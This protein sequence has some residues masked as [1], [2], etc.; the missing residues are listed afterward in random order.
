MQKITLTIFIA[1]SSFGFAQTKI[2]VERQVD[3]DKMTTVVT[4][5]GYYYGKTTCL[6]V[7]TAKKLKISNNPDNFQI[8]HFDTNF[9]EKGKVSSYTNIG[10]SLNNEALKKLDGYYTSNTKQ[11][12]RLYVSP[13]VAINR[14]TKDTIYLNPIELK[15]TAE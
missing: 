15:L 12:I 1:L 5:A 3:Q 8:I 6:N 11:T 4:L 13:I 9:G 10:D 2:K 7:L 14:T